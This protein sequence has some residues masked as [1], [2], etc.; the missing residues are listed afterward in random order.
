[1]GFV[2]DNLHQRAVLLTQYL[3]RLPRT[4]SPSTSSASSTNSFCGYPLESTLPLSLD[5]D[6]G[7]MQEK[8]AQLLQ[9]VIRQWT[10]NGQS[11]NHSIQHLRDSFLHRRGKLI[12]REHDWLLQV[13]Q[14]AFDV[15]LNGLPW[16]IRMIQLPWMREVLWVEWV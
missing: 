2:Q 10:F 11:V 1:M 3:A 7:R 13:E 14:K 6:A 8:A 16:N 15:M 4:L 5:E 9:T 12:R